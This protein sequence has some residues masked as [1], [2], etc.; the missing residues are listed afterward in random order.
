MTLDANMLPIYRHA[1]LIGFGHKARQGKDLAVKLLAEAFPGHVARVAFADALRVV[2]RVQHG[3]TEKDAP[4]LQRV[5]VDA[6]AGDPLVWVRAAAWAIWELDAEADAPFLV[7]LPDTRFGNEAAFVRARGITCRLE[8][9]DADGRRVV[10]TDRAADHPSEVDL[11]AYDWQH[12]VRARTRDELRAG[13]VGMAAGLLAVPVSET[14][15]PDRD[16]PPAFDILKS[17]TIPS[18]NTP[19]TEYHPSRRCSCAS[20]QSGSAGIFAADSSGER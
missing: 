9:F 17:R 3:M 8:R 18:G 19:D 15:V 1:R 11:D 2:C 6:R 12:T 14:H 5:G 7:C 4:L 20:C 13:V 16:T 10:A